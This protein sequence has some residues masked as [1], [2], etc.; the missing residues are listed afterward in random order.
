[1]DVRDHIPDIFKNNKCLYLH[2]LDLWVEKVIHTKAIPCVELYMVLGH[3]SFPAKLRERRVVLFLHSEE[4]T[5]KLQGH[6]SPIFIE[7]T[8]SCIHTVSS[9]IQS[10][11]IVFTRQ[12]DNTKANG[13]RVLYV[14]FYL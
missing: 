8:S 2:C 1:M 7:V 10:P 13:E 12:F 5:T 6:R 3:V 14:Y 9:I 4:N 11:L